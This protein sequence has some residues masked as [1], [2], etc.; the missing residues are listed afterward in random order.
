MGV[1]IYYAFTSLFALKSS[2]L[3]RV[4]SCTPEVGP[5]EEGVSTRPSCA[6]GDRDAEG[7]T[8]GVEMQIWGWA[9]SP[10]QPTGSFLWAAEVVGTD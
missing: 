8:S 7:S 10:W 6:F 3:D 4:S 2:V 1:A 5:A 9:T